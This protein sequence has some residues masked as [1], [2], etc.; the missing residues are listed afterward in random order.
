MADERL[1]AEL[2]AIKERVADPFTSAARS[3]EDVPRLVK[4]L[5]AVLA[6]HHE[7]FTEPGFCAGCGFALPCATIRAITSAL[8]GT[9]ADGD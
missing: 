3:A 4:A 6:E 7:A 8:T 1:T 2:A 5:E 9:G